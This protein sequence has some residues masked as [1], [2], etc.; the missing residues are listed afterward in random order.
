MI[1]LDGAEGDETAH[2]D[3][4][5]LVV[6]EQN[7]QFVFH[8]SFICQ[9][10]VGMERERVSVLRQTRKE[11]MYHTHGTLLDASTTALNMVVVDVE[12]NEDLRTPYC[13][14]REN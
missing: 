7:H 8:V 9:L 12:M 6:L 1:A 4:G 14:D 13:C 3:E 2:L 10:R 5:E 11:K